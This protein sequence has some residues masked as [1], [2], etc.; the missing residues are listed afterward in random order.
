MTAFFSFGGGS[1]SC[2]GSTN[3][4]GFASCSAIVTAPAGTEVG[5]D[6]CFSY[7]QQVFCAPAGYIVQ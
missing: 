7:Q 2:S 3:T 5:I 1:G 6:A 4:S